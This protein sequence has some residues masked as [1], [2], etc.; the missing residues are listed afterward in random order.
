MG[1]AF[2]S[3]PRQ[4]PWVMSGIGVAHFPITTNNPEV[5]RWFDQ[6]NALLHSFDYYEA[7]RSFRW[8]LKL[9]PGNAMAY[10]GLAVATEV[11]DP[12][13]KSRS[14]DFIREAAKRKAS[15]TERERLFIEAWEAAL[16]PDPLRAAEADGGAEWR[17]SE[18]TKR[19][20]TL[21]VKFPDDM[22]A[23]AYLA[24]MTMGDDRYGTELIIREILAHQ[25]LHPGAHH[26]RIHNWDY[27]E[28]EQALAS[29]RIYSEQVT[30]IGHAQ[31]MPG[32]IY[33]IVGMWDEAAISMDAAT[34]VEKRY[35]QDS[36]TF[37]FDNWN[38][39]HNRSY[40]SYI[41]EQLG[42]PDEA[43]AG[44][45]Q[46]I[47]APLDPQR[48]ADN[49]R[50]TQSA[51]MRSL[52]R[53]LLKY[54]RWDQL[55]SK[56]TFA[57]R[58]IPEDRINKAYV[59]ARAWLGKGDVTQAQK[60]L[61]AHARLSKDGEADGLKGIYE[62]QE[63]ELKGRLGI[64]RGDSLIGLGLLAEA[65]EREFNQQRSY[66]DP[67]VYPESLYN[68]LG[69]AYLDARSPF[70][71]GE[72]F[73]KALSLTRNDLFA[74]S[75]LVRAYA[76]TGERA[77]AT[78]AMARL[79]FVTRN[80]DKG[81]RPLEL[82][83]ATGI[84]AEPRDAS[85]AP[86]RNYGQAALGQFGPGT[87]EPYAAPALEAH[88]ASG[89]VVTLAS[90]A[91]KN[92]I[93]VFYLG[94]ECSLC[95]EQLQAIGKKQGDWDALGTVVLAV[96]SPA[97]SANADAMRILGKLPITQLS[98]VDHAN[99]RRF[100]SYDDFEDTELHS[101]LL[102]DKQGRVYWGRFGGEPFTDMDFLEKQLK[103]M[104][105]RVAPAAVAVVD[106]SAGKSAS[107]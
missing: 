34:R 16:L 8:C 5:Q 32:H 63:L 96:S 69:E 103:R 97:P 54:Q 89:Q 75:G 20:E 44:A 76:A 37:T 60:A 79:L 24:L 21:C 13:G 67:P 30:A 70:L 19:L 100:R 93:L 64:A 106:A 1:D 11:Y 72:A 23:R 50:S 55:L 6:G 15:V 98:D 83:R 39:G 59:E 48:N 27:N 43:L 56:E 49:F 47:D 78:D 88:D 25:P 94:T 95:M 105:A 87:W 84:T 46:L 57:W 4:K 52:E 29:C 17:K 9:E 91:G 40:L 45:R 14:A 2:D 107:P 99:A 38:Y 22:E 10:W 62:I 65:A 73:E 61:E 92:V 3:G 101:T 7:E 102:I 71:A 28:P 68:A 53:V 80:G 36:L 81:L 42:M 104:N 66:S 85:P 51:G 31:H 26:Y 86:Q 18:R 90:Y 74:L 82:A 41:Q 35:M 12:S 77:K 58:D 33:S